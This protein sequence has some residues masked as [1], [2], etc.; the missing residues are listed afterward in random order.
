MFVDRTGVKSKEAEILWLSRE[1]LAK[2][3]RIMEIGSEPFFE[4]ALKSILRTLKGSA[5]TNS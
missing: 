5:A 3:A 4:R 2:R 1:L